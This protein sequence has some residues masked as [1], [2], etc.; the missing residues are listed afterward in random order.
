M[1]YA[2]ANGDQGQFKLMGDEH[3]SV[4]ERKTW[5]MSA[6]L[7][8]A[9]ELSDYISRSELI[10]DYLYWKQALAR[11]EAA[12]AAIKQLERKKERFEEC[13]RFGHFH[14]NYHE[15]LEE[16]Q[17]AQAAVDEFDTVREFKRAEEA[18]DEL[19]YDVSKMVAH[20]VSESIKVPTNKL[21]P[22][23]GGCGSGGSCSGKCG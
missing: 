19:L 9:Y 16:A 12:Q 5:D 8:G 7:L 22:D 15:A 13:Q 2:H 18:L 21:L 20:A 11:D 14:P 23:S 10:A 17:R 3:M 6:I 4:L 1:P